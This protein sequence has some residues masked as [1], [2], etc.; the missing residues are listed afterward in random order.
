MV[1]IN[2]LRFFCEVARNTSFSKAA[3]VCC[4][5]Q[6]T[7]SNTI[8]QLED[9]LQGKL[10]NRSTRKVKLTA[11]G[12][13]VLPLAEATLATRD[14]FVEA[15]K[16]FQ[17]PQ[18]KLLRIGLSPLIDMRLLNE[19]L[20]PFK[21]RHEH[22]E[23]FFKECYLDDLS[24]RMDDETIDLAIMPKRESHIRFATMPLYAE[25]LYFLP[26]EHDGQ[27]MTGSNKS[28]LLLS[29]IVDENIIL[30]AGGCGLGDSIKTLFREASLEF[31]EYSG[32][33]VSY[34]AIE[35]WAGLG[36][37]AGILPQSTFSEDHASAIPL[38]RKAGMQA[39]IEYEVSYAKNIEHASHVNAFLTYLQEIAPR[40][41]QGRVQSRA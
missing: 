20:Q 24:H 29:D 9:V 2:Q 6:P 17:N 13:H 27:V 28:A 16:A 12:A 26:C 14:E 41:I 19:I 23:V 32:Q 21:A 7:L 36:I 33:A 5:T 30:T 40:L 34:K 25:A 18:H 4:V 39:M 11:F 8:A 38:L 31:K 37:G 15:A 22:V 10:F 1:N 3:D 35:D